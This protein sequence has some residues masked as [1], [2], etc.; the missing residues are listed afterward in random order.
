[1]GRKR[2]RP[3]KVLSARISK[4]DYEKLKAQAERSGKTISQIWKELINSGVR[5]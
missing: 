3:T 2:K 1:M 4:S 5:R